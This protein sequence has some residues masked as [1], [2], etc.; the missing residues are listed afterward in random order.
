MFHPGECNSDTLCLSQKIVC[1]RYFLCQPPAGCREQVRDE[2][3]HLSQ[4]AFC[5]HWHRRAG[6][7]H[8]RRGQHSQRRCPN[9][10]WCKSTHCVSLFCHLPC[11][12][13]FLPASYHSV[14]IHFCFNSF[15][16]HDL[17]L[18][19]LFP[20]YFLQTSVCIL[21]ILWALIL[22]SFSSLCISVL[23]VKSMN[24]YCF[25]VLW[26]KLSF[27]LN[28]TCTH[29]TFIHHFLRK[30]DKSL[31]FFFILYLSYFDPVLLL[32]PSGIVIIFL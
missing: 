2:P 17:N 19:F 31:L 12:K 27:I 28:F 3:S 21:S 7:P 22:F 15:C 9:S 26:H 20:V 30:S 32:H 6:L 23:S 25:S 16:T 5:V 18:F 24:Q 13:P 11:R 4:G 14:H 10:P 8:H 1:L 29:H